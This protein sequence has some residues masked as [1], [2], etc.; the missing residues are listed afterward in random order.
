M[1]RLYH[2][3]NLQPLPSLQILQAHFS[4]NPITGDLHGLTPSVEHSLD[5]LKRRG[6]TDTRISFLSQRI[7]IERIAWKL[8]YG[9]DPPSIL[10]TL[11]GNHFNL[12]KTN[13]ATLIPAQS[14]HPLY[15]IWTGMIYRCTRQTHVA[16]S[17]YGGRGI[18][19]CERWLNSFSA[20]VADMGPRPTGTS[21]HRINNNLGYEPSNC[22]WATDAE[23]CLPGSKRFR[24]LKLSNDPMRNISV[25]KYRSKT[26]RLDMRLPCSRTFRQC[27]ASLDEAQQIRDLVEYERE[28]YKALLLPDCYDFAQA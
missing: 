4:Y 27:F 16:Y 2:P 15:P 24:R 12:R 20:F 25:Q 8:A 5:C 9:E 7:R 23:Q 1:S 26:Y 21:I 18:Q 10:K 13:L 17:N 22:K 11:D 19:V 28:I 14:S 6:G 3:G